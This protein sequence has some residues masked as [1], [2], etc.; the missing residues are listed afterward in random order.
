MRRSTRSGNSDATYRAIS[1]RGSSSELRWRTSGWYPKVKECACLVGSNTAG[2]L[3]HFTGTITYEENHTAEKTVRNGIRTQA[4]SESIRFQQTSVLT[5]PRK[6]GMMVDSVASG[7]KL[8]FSSTTDDRP[9]CTVTSESHLQLDG[10]DNDN[11]L[12]SININAQQGRYSLAFDRLPLDGSGRRRNVF[13]VKG[14]ACG[15]F[16]KPR[17]ETRPAFDGIGP[18]VTLRTVQ[19]EID[20]NEPYALKGSQTFEKHDAFYDVTRTGTLTWDL[21]RCER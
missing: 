2:A 16:N 15:V 20:P 17:N 8:Q 6:T 11:G 9:G 13:N 7:K 18:L 12:V 4:S 21:Q 1:A 19:G 14:E 3:E 10:R 5:F